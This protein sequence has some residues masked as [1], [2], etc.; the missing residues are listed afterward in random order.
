MGFP[1]PKGAN[2]SVTGVSSKVVIPRGKKLLV[3]FPPALDT[4]YLTVQTHTVQEVYGNIPIKPPCTCLLFF[5]VTDHCVFFSPT[6]CAWQGRR[7]GSRGAAWSDSKWISVSDELPDIA[8]LSSPL[9][10]FWG[11]FS[12]TKFQ[13]MTRWR[14]RISIAIP[15]QRWFTVN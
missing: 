8:K 6:G 14:N 11:I 2:V 12:P 15:L 7:E 13:G 9:C 4:E 3:N 1:G 10:N 5:P